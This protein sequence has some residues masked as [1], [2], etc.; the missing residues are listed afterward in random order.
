VLLSIFDCPVLDY[1]QE[2]IVILK[3]QM[4]LKKTLVI[5]ILIV[6][7]AYAKKPTRVE[8]ETNRQL[9]LDTC[10]ITSKLPDDYFSLAGCQYRECKLDRSRW[11]ERLECVHTY[12]AGIAKFQITY[13][14]TL[15]LESSS[16]HAEETGDLAYCM[17]KEFRGKCIR[18]SWWW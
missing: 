9:L 3:T 11:P 18:S 15:V 13:S 5:L 14:G 16:F 10:V 12:L 2:K 7:L 17:W 6:S 8:Y 4:H 1:I